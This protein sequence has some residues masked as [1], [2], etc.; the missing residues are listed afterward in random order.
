MGGMTLSPTTTLPTDFPK[1]ALAGRVFR[2]DV[3]GP[4]VV[5]VRDGEVF[6]ISRAFPT[7]RDL[8][9]TSAPA[10]ALREATGESLGPLEAILAN[11]VEATRDPS[12]PY[13][14][15]PTRRLISLRMAAAASAL[16][17]A[18]SS[19]TRSS[20]ET[21]KVTPAALTACRSNGARR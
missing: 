21:A 6:D 2:P 18:R 1:A 5:A 7:M 4:S 19:M 20:M 14:L 9:E 10:A 8:C 12:R 17:R 3:E 16:P 13:L 11:S 15:A